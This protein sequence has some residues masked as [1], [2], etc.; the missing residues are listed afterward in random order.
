MLASVE[1]DLS[2]YYT[3]TETDEL[4]KNVEV[5]LTGYATEKWVEDKG[6]L[7]E[8]QSLAGY[9]TEE[10]VSIQDYA[11]KTWIGE[12]G[13]LKEENNPAHTSQLVNDGEDGSSK[14][15]TIKEVEDILSRATGGES[16]GDVLVALNDHKE[17]LNNPHQVTA[18]QVGAYST[19]E[20][21]NKVNLLQTNLN[22][23]EETKANKEELFSGSYND[24]SD[25]P[26]IPDDYII[27]D[28][29]TSGS[30]LSEDKLAIVLANPHKVILRSSG[31]YFYL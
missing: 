30:S 11:S 9:A 19:G 7:T 16:A 23:L 31:N 12:Q 18:A 14:F 1:V 10:W 2:D 29:Y 5:D 17:D 26:T 3:K 21:D 28:T 25:K 13:F 24:L 8:H 22:I 27:I 20:I 4:L 15:A 6:Y